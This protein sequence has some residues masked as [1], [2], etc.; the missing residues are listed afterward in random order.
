LIDRRSVHFHGD[1]FG[2]FLL[3]PETGSEAAY[4]GTHASQYH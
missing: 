1:A 2:S 4:R 3:R